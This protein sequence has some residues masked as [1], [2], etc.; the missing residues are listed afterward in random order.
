VELL[1][2]VPPGPGLV[3]AYAQL[4][5]HLLVRGQYGESLNASE[6]ALTLAG[7]LG[8]PVPARAL[9]FHGSALCNTGQAAA[10]GL[11]EQKEARALLIAEGRGRDAAVAMHNLAIARWTL[12]GPGAAIQTLEE[13]ASFAAQ[14]GLLEAQGSSLAAKLERLVDAGRFGDVIAEADRLA[15][16]ADRVSLHYLSRTELNAAVG[17]V[18]L[19]RGETS[20]AARSADAAL[21]IVLRNPLPL[22]MAIAA[23]PAAS[24]RL[25]GG[26]ATGA[27]ELLNEVAEWTDGPANEEY[28]ARLP[29]YVRCAVAAGDLSLAERLV[30]R[31]R[32]ELPLHEH[33]LAA[34]QALLA[35]SRGEHAGAAER[36]CD[37]AA[38]W[39]GFGAVL[40]Q[41]YALLGQGR[42][43]V[44]L[45]DPDA[46]Q[47]LRR[48]RRVFEGMGARPRV[49]DCDAL[50]SETLAAE[51]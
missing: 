48:A 35:E 17:R 16:L 33:A 19:E 23:C 15:K 38:R 5:G 24:A 18:Q 27:R 50:L 34:A 21:E 44:A 11:V 12:E 1:E 10:V 46:G 20:A 6:R 30:E 2:S 43:L 4:S 40:E 28:L 51:A 45:G 22:P 3:A 7:E 26:D 29:A 39:E 9:G 37:A 32:P 36:F 42:C 13:A 47:P 14:R 25:A 8:L 49:A 41:A 31:V